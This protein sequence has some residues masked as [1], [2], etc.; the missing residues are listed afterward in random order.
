MIAIMP[1][2][3]PPSKCAGVRAS[4]FEERHG[5]Y[6]ILLASPAGGKRAARPRKESCSRRKLLRSRWAAG[7]R[8]SARGCP[9]P[10]ACRWDGTDRGSRYPVRREPCG[11]QDPRLREGSRSLG[12]ARPGTNDCSIPSGSAKLCAARRQAKLVHARL[13]RVRIHSP[14]TGRPSMVRIRFGP[15]MVNS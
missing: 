1:F 4:F 15:V 6:Q 3:I 13:S 11:H 5:R 10:P 7:K 8:K 14:D 2:W 9:F 12:N